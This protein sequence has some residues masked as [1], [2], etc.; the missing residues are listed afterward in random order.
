M[1]RGILMEKLNYEEM[2]RV[3]GGFFWTLGKITIAIL[4]TTF[5]SGIIDGFIRP[6]KCN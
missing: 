6:L 5:F 4:G 1:V 2:M 3:N